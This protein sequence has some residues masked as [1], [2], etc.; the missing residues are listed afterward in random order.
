M[1]AERGTRYDT[2]HLAIE[3]L[4]SAHTG[5]LF[6][7]LDDPAVHRF[8]LRP[9]V[10]TPEA[11]RARIEHLAVGPPPSHS[12]ERWWNFAVLLRAERTV[13]GRLEATTYGDWGEIAYVFGPRWWGQ[14]L[15]A[16]ATRW[17]IQHLVGHGVPELW[18]AVH[19]ANE[20][21]KRL[22][23]RIGFAAVAVAARP[24]ASFDRGDAVFVWQPAP[25]GPPPSPPRR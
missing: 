9:D 24:Q 13:I 21:S 17:L 7:A 10:T 2:L 15:A 11:L 19:P 23:A 25:H 20:P 8:L 5:G 16:E 18:A 14:G 4:A 3:P 12:G 22:L 6:A 1:D